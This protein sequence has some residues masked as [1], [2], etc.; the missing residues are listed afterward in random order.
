[1]KKFIYVVI[2]CMSIFYVS[3]TLAKPI[4]SIV[5]IV[6]SDIITQSQFDQAVMEARQQ[7][8]HNHI[9]VPNKKE[10]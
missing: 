5:A 7:L 2:A 3:A 1:M 8:T 9:A 6:N 10:A 4:N